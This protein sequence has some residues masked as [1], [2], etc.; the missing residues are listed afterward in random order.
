MMELD[1]CPNC[2]STIENAYI[3]KCAKCGKIQCPDCGRNATRGSLCSYL[4]VEC[5]ENSLSTIGLIRL[6]D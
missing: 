1:C 3:L 6:R 5:G 4:C 2:F